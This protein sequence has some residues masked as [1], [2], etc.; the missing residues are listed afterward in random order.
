VRD[1]FYPPTETGSA[2]AIPPELTPPE[3]LDAADLD[4]R[5]RR[6]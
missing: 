4:E 6:R 5:G 3:I 1:A 2:Y